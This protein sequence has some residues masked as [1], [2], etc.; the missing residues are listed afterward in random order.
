MTCILTKDEVKLWVDLACT[1]S[2]SQKT[3]SKKGWKILI[4]QV[5]YLKTFVKLPLQ[6]ASISQIVTRQAAV[7]LTPITFAVWAKFGA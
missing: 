1:I 6:K 7:I 4:N 5:A 3:S 2:D